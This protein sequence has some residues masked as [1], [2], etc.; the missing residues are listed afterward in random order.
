[1]GRLANPNCAVPESLFEL[2]HGL[3]FRD[4]NLFL[5]AQRS[6]TPSEEIF[7]TRVD[8]FVGGG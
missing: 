7:A 6:R 3:E 2:L 4:G 1:M 8:G 5:S